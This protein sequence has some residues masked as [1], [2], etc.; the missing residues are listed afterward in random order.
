[1]EQESDGI[2]TVISVLDTVTKGIVQGL[3][4]LKIRGWVETI[5]K[6][7]CQELLEYWEES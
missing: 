2:H 5:Q 6:Q 3:E 4:D 1:M 7:H